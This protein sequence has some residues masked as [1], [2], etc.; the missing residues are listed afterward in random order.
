[1]NYIRFGEIDQYGILLFKLLR[2]QNQ[3][4]Q[5]SALI[6][7]RNHLS[8]KANCRSLIYGFRPVLPQPP[9]HLQIPTSLPTH[10]PSAASLHLRTRRQSPLVL[11]RTL[12]RGHRRRP[13]WKWKRTQL[14]GHTANTTLYTDALVQ[15]EV[16]RTPA[17]V[18][19][20]RVRVRKAQVIRSACDT[21][22]FVTEGVEWWIGIRGILGRFGAVVEGYHVLYHVRHFL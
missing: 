17:K 6:I 9:P 8:H 12:Q 13:A 11:Q 7:S 18:P 3:S 22:P 19:A 4:I 15:L 2:Y 1:M 21:W 5:S 14:V 20:R 10:A 16:T